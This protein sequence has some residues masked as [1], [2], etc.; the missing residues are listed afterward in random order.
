MT[1]WKTILL[2]LVCLFGGLVGA[3]TWLT[4]ESRG[5]DVPRITKEQLKSELGNPEVVVLDVRTE[6]DWNSS[7]SKIKGAVRENPGDVKSWLDK[8]PKDK[9]IV[10]YCA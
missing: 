5:V 7:N 6:G 9:M 8:Y 10:L 4:E 2:V 3:L 1:G